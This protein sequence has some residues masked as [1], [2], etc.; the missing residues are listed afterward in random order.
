M[1]P[2]N[3]GHGAE[4]ITFDLGGTWFRSAL[5]TSEGQLCNLRRVPSINYRSFPGKSAVDLVNE[6][7]YYI[8]TTVRSLWPHAE[9]PPRH[10]P[11]AI[12]MGAA[13]NAHTGMILGSGP[14][15]GDASDPFDLSQSIRGYLPRANIFIV[16]DV[17]ASLIAHS[18]L[19]EFRGSHRLALITVSSGIASRILDCSVP[20]VPVDP[21]LGIQGEIG[22]HRVAVSVNG[23]PLSLNCDCGGSNHL[24]AFSSGLGIQRVLCKVRQMFPEEFRASALSQSEE[25]FDVP[26]NLL[27][28]CLEDGDVFSHK[29][30]RA[31][32]APLAEA[33]KWHF[34]LDP[35]IEK[36]I[37]TGGTC[38]SLGD[39]YLSAILENLCSSEFYPLSVD[40]ETFWSDRVVMG[41]CTD[42]AGL[43]GAA[44]V[45]R[46]LPKL[47][48]REELDSHPPYRVSRRVA[49]DYSVVIRE[50]ILEEGTFPKQL[51]DPFDRV[52]MVCDQ[53]VANIYGEALPILLAGRDRVV[54]CLTLSVSEKQK[55]LFTVAEVIAEFETHGVTRRRDLI[56][57]VGG[58][59]VLDLVAFASSI[60]RR[61]VP[62]MKIPTTLL[63]QIDAGVGVK[64]GINVRQN[65]SRLGTYCA[66][67]A[68]VVDPSF[69]STLPDRQIRNGLSEALKIALVA[70]PTLFE[71]I[72]LHAFDLIR[73]KLQSNDGAEVIRRSI[74][75]MLCELSPNLSE[76]N[77]ERLPDYG[78]T[79]S[80]IFE[81]ELSDLEHGEAVALDMSIATALAIRLGILDRN[82]AERIF[83]THQALGLPITREGMTPEMLQRAIRDAEKHRGGRLRMPLLRRVGEATFI[84]VVSERELAEALAY[85]Q[86]WSSAFERAGLRRA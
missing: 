86:C 78:H 52:I 4:I 15:L 14:I 70:D 41:P 61:G 62:C 72:E 57:A 68:V 59:I 11:I 71:L 37:L 2:F 6:I 30:L 44:Y 79:F 67:Y 63:A 39:S 23:Q 42:D 28:E 21:V 74:R 17:T 27:R 65:K 58:G 32:T 9:S 56:V 83:L 69:L 45:A 82:D 51:L 84:N 80:P 16:N 12:S 47:H 54:E 26:L 66:P 35:E 38:F 76:R 60:F 53:R 25:S 24:N 7:S 85:V 5:L 81:F 31:V 64:T 19:P 29:I 1:S 8:A 46:E 22:H 10:P 20:H 55:D 77:L 40:Q 75:A 48:L 49:I 33:I 18:K 43:A 3:I 50:N 34:M 73:T 13:L 36:I